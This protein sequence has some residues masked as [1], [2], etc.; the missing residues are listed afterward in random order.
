MC[1][2]A[3]I[4]KSDGAFSPDDVAAVLRMIDAQEHRGP[5]DWGILVPDSLLRH[6]EVQRLLEPRGT[7]QVGSYRNEPG[8]AA[9][10]LGSTRL[11]ILDLSPHGHMP[12]GGGRTWVT[13]NG[14]IYNCGELRDELKE[15]DFQS[16]GDTEVIIKGYER[17]GDDALHR[18][19]GMFALAV[20]DNTKS[21][22]LLAR[23]RFGIKPLYYNWKDVGAGTLVFAS[24]VRALV[25][26][27]LVPNVP[28]PEAAVRFLQLGSVPAPLTTIKN[29]FALPAGHTLAADNRGVSINRYWSLSAPSSSSYDSEEQVVARTAELFNESVSQHLLS[30]V[31]L[32][33]FLSGGIDSSALVAVAQKFRSQPLTTLSMVFA[34]AEYSESRYSSLVANRYHTDHRETRLTSDELLAEL[35]NVFAAMDQPTVDGVN[36]YFISRAAKQAGLKVVL[37]GLGGDELFLGYNHFKKARS[38]SSPMRW[39]QKL[40][41]GVRRS[42]VS[43]A[44][45]GG[46]FA[47]RSGSE[48]LSYLQD[49]SAANLYLM[50]RG[51]FTLD[52][53][54]KLLGLSAAEMKRYG[55]HPA[56][57]NGAG[58]SSLV[59]SFVVNEFQHYLQDQLLKD[60]DCMSMA[61]SIETRVPFLDH[62][63][64]QYVFGAP[65]RFKFDGAMT[66]PL[67]LKALGEDFPREVWDR[68]KMGFTFPFAPWL[69]NQMAEFQPD[70]ANSIINKTE[71]EKIRHGFQQGSVH[72]SRPW[73]L[74]V[75][76][77]WQ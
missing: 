17:W 7:D 39:W 72:W 5:D 11:S 47:G 52:Q 62:E 60:T 66:K 31:P 29:V 55:T 4:F 16:T 2:I 77:Q 34:E 8:S 51:L 19:R 35:P 30:D 59:N 14:E 6:D 40:P 44:Q 69:R 58:E 43:V 24:E 25:S 28:E 10:I 1:G 22:L 53:I 70:S 45:Q 27:G 68:P 46:K 57:V 71:A 73:A 3:G 76:E 23:D 33:I 74:M 61:H 21:R 38:L 41:N 20:F 12:M 37:S 36:S 9:V 50:F 15:A 32:G 26:S 64:V 65:E 63:L 67:L 49:A 42:V 13:H 18:L 75:L 48:K 54:Q 56:T